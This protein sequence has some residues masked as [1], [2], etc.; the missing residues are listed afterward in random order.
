MATIVILYRL[1]YCKE[2]MTEL[3]K[4]SNLNKKLNKKTN[5]Q[6]LQWHQY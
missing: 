1:H 5:Q 4:N 3:I 2:L 6:D